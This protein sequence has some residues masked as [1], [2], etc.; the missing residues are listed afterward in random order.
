MNLLIDF[1]NTRLKWAPWIA[2]Q[3]GEG[4]VF[5]HAEAS[6]PAMLERE[7]TGLPRPERVLVASVVKPELE[8]ALEDL[9]AGMFARPTQFVRSPASALG[10]VNA[11]AEHERLGVDRF[12][13]LAALHATSKQGQV[14]VGCGTA[15]TLD[16]LCADGRHLGGL[17]APSPQLM[18]EALGRSTARAGGARG[19]LTEIADNT[20]DAVHSGSLLAAAAL[21]RRFKCGVE[22]SMGMPLALIG[23]G[24]GIEELLPLLPDL[25]RERDLVLRGLA[26]WAEHACA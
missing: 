5:A 26:L 10:I 13:A 4:G 3:P 23:D 9:V 15:L 20:A 6:L 17:I 7:W 22:R 21:I 12:L 2:G 19:M 24:G 11:Y 14:L 16:A 25:Q 1:G 18:R 8:H